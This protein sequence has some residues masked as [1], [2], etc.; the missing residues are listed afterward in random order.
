MAAVQDQGA[1]VCVQRF[2]GH[3]RSEDTLN[4]LKIRCPI[5]VAIW[6]HFM[7]L[8]LAKIIQLGVTKM[9]ADFSRTNTRR[10]LP[11][12]FLRLSGALR[13][14]TRSDSLSTSEGRRLRCGLAHLAHNLLHYRVD[15]PLLMYILKWRSANLLLFISPLR[16]SHRAEEWEAGKK[17]GENN[18]ARKTQQWI[19]G[20]PTPLRTAEQLCTFAK[21]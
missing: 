12:A 20:P 5:S 14:A 11:S 8:S 17:K 10:F 4:W 18:D 6:A 19:P 7:D 21:S 3:Y 2:S 9:E 16:L 15:V 1:T 13:G